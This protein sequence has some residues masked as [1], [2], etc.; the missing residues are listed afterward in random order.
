MSNNAGGLCCGEK[1]EVS[2]EILKVTFFIS[3]C[4]ICVYACRSRNV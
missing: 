3:D 4:I 1:N 2:N